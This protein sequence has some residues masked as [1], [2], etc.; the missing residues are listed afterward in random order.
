MFRRHQGL[1]LHLRLLHHGGESLCVD[2]GRAIGAPP[3]HCQWPK[4]DSETAFPWRRNET[5]S[6]IQQILNASSTPPQHYRMMSWNVSD[7]ISTSNTTTP[8]R[9]VQWTTETDWEHPQ[10]VSVLVVR[11]PLQRLLATDTGYLGQTYPDIQTETANRSVWW[12]FARDPINENWM[13]RQLVPSNTIFQGRAGLLQAQALAR[14]MTFVLDMECLNEG[15][16]ALA[17]VLG[18]DLHPS[19]RPRHHIPSHRIP[20]PD[21]QELLERRN[22]MDME[23]YIWCKT[24]RL[25]QCPR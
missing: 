25:V 19:R 7:N 2:V 11:H 8:S 21:V 3:I 22:A 15:L 1:L 13:I 10:L 20:Y 9:S 12:A 23:F 17:E 14:R 5:S 6:R 4:N 24:I 16:Q 18:F